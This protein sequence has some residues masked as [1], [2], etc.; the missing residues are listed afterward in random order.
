MHE[1]K[2]SVKTLSPLV[3]SAA[4]NATLMTESHAEI[5]GSIMR[6]VLANRYIKEKNLRDE[7][8]K[9]ENFR[10]LFYGGLKFLSATPAISN[11][12][13]FTLP[14][15][16]QRGKKGTANAKNIADLFAVETPPA[17]YKSLRGYGIVDG[18]KIFTASVEKNIYMHMSRSAEKERISGKSEEGHIYNYEALEAGQNFCGSIIGAETDLKKLQLEN[19]SFV[20]RI[21][22]SRFTQYGKCEFIFEKITEIEAPKFGEKIYLRLESPL[23]PFED[24]FI[25]AEKVLTN[26]VIKKLGEN[27]S[28][29]KVFAAGVEIENFIKI[30]GMKSPRVMALAAGSVFEI[31]SENLTPADKNN[32]AE[33]IYSGFGVRTEEGFGQLRIW[34]PKNFTPAKLENKITKPEFSEQTI[35]IAKN[36]LLEKYLEQL[37]IYAHEDAKNLKFGDGNFTHFFSRLNTLLSSVEKKNLREKFSAKISDECKGGK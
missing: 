11:R 25:G 19:K 28:L 17:G 33:K 7:A 15:S 29:G 30:W 20:E 35:K 2:F 1:I 36:I 3:I 27:F 8:Y 22:R 32:L 21:G 18:D 5:S 31:I 34:S 9:D 12:R 16:L 13:S 10:K 6:G 37:R 26:E 24:N 14:L 23:I 4:S